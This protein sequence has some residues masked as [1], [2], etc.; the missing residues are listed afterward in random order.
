MHRF[1]PVT[2]ANFSDLQLAKY[3]NPKLLCFPPFSSP[4]LP[5]HPIPNRTTER[6]A[7]VLPGL[8]AP[9]MRSHRMVGI[10][11]STTAFRSIA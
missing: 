9:F 1:V 5:R 3:I 7:F 4:H 10:V 2:S 11:Q 8:G 6:S